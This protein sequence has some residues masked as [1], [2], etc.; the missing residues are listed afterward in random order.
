MF[1]CA[2]KRE[3]VVDLVV[4]D[5]IWK[6][7]HRGD[8]AL[9]A[10]CMDER[11]ARLGMKAEAVAIFRGRALSTAVTDELSMAVA[12]WRPALHYKINPL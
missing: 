7:I 12:K 4:S 11:L 2:C 10:L 9:C 8:Y 3:I 5:E 1:R 6:L